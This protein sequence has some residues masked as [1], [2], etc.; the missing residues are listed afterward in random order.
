MGG[1]AWIQTMYMHSTCIDKQLFTDASLWKES[2]RKRQYAETLKSASFIC[3]SSLIIKSITKT[4]NI[5]NLFFP[6]SI[7][8]LYKRYKYYFQFFHKMILLLHKR[9]LHKELRDCITRIIRMWSLFCSIGVCKS[10]HF[11]LSF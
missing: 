2:F 8:I 1:G 11:L 9:L 10:L 6:A 7:N 3:L 5:Q 4:V